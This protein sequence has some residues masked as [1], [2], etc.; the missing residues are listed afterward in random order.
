MTPVVTEPRNS[1]TQ[2]IANGNGRLTDHQTVGI[3]K[4]SNRQIFLGINLYNSKIRRWIRPQHAA[5]I[6][7]SV[8][9]TDDKFL[10]AFDD[11]VIGRD[12]PSLL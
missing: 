6:S 11:M 3:A 4:F 10:G 5:R 7:P 1:K 9:Q 2:G 8:R 12:K